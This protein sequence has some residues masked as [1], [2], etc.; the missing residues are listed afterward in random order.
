MCNICNVQLTVNH[1]LI[2]C[3][4]YQNTRSQYYSETTL[5]ELFKNE[6]FSKIINFLKEIGLYFK[7]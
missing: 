5:K 6:R 3:I 7:F 1:I 4:D 2:D